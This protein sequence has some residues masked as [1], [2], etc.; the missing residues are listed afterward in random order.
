[1]KYINPFSIK[2]IFKSIFYPVKA[3]EDAAVEYIGL[4]NRV[5]TKK[6]IE[7]DFDRLFNRRRH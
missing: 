7:K 2:K 4:H 5:K 6:E 3:A 1:M